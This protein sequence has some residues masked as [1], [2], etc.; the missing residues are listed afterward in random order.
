[1]IVI[2]RCQLQNLLSKYSLSQ[3]IRVWRNRIALRSALRQLGAKKGTSAQQ[4]KPSR[5]AA[6]MAIA[7]RRRPVADEVGDG[8]TDGLAGRGE[9]LA[10]AARPNTFRPCRPR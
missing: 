6:R 4:G 1:M 3:W 10:A 7:D 8:Q 2:E 5:D 9:A